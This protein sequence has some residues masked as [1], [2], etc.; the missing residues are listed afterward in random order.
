[1][2][3][4]RSRRPPDQH[5]WTRCPTK[6]AGARPRA[7]NGQARPGAGPRRRPVR[8]LGTP[9]MIFARFPAPA[10]AHMCRP[11]TGVARAKGAERGAADRSEQR[12][13]ESRGRFSML[14]GLSI[15]LAA[16]V[17]ALLPLAAA[18]QETTIRVGWTIP[19]EESKYWIMRR[20]AEF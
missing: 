17:S 8:S 16:W 13:R 18:A 19:A 3:E 12:R 5:S 7:G 4:P 10:G 20:P 11:Y 6:V 9:A 14:K 1:P 2:L 15:V